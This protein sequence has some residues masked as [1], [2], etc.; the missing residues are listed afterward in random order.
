MLPLVLYDTPGN[1]IKAWNG[2]TLRIRYM[3]HILFWEELSL[4]VLIC[5]YCL[6]IKN[7]PY[8]TMWV[9]YPDIE[10]TLRALRAAPTGVVP[11]FKGGERPF[12]TVPA[13]TDPN[14]LNEEGK[15]TVVVESSK[16]AAYLD[17][18]YPG[19]GPVLV[20]SGTKGFQAVFEDYILKTF[21]YPCREIIIPSFYEN[22]TEG[23]KP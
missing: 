17:K 18:Y 13:I 10:P 21:I 12:Y 23:S 3:L 4:R 5:R 1:K 22:L 20:P 9:E 11:D 14:T 19:V 8:T 6:G 7:I 16:I 15:P 2:A